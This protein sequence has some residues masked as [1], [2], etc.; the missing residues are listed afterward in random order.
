MATGLAD[1]P[2]SSKPMKHTFVVICAT[3]PAH[4]A[5]ARVSCTDPTW[6]IFE[7]SFDDLDS[8]ARSIKIDVLVV[9]GT[10]IALVSARKIIAGSVH[11][12]GTVVGV[13]Y[14]DDTG[15]AVAR[16]LAS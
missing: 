5:L 4:R 2:Y 13:R 12:I 3:D 10:A 16:A 7:C 15:A 11:R 9:I 6:Y 8:V 14:A 1:H